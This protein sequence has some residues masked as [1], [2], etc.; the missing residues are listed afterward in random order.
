VIAQCKRNLKTVKRIVVYLK[1][2]R[3]TYKRL[4][5]LREVRYGVMIR[6][7]KLKG[8]YCKVRDHNKQKGRLDIL[9]M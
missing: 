4:Q 3:R 6:F 9:T 8:E 5:V 7:K 1:E 2:L